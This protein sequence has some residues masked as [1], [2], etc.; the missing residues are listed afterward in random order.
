MLTAIAV[1]S[2]SG[3]KQHE[4]ELAKITD[5]CKENEYLQQLAQHISDKSESARQTVDDLR[6][7]EQTWTLAA[8]AEASAKRRC[9]LLA[10]ATEARGRQTSAASD[11]AA[12]E[13]IYSKAKLQIAK[14]QGT[15]NAVHTALKMK[16]EDG[17]VTSTAVGT[18]N[19]QKIAL[20]IANSNSA[21]CQFRVHSGKDP[22]ADDPPKFDQIKTMKLTAAAS[23]AN[24]LKPTTIAASGITGSCT[25]T[26]ATGGIQARLV[27]CQIAA[28]T[29]TTYTFSTPQ[30]TSGDAQTEVHIFADDTENSD[31]AAGLNNLPT[32]ATDTQR[33]AK[34]ICD[35]LKH[36]PPAVQSLKGSTGQTLSALDSIQLFIR[37]C[38]PDFQSI[39][40]AHSGPKAEKLKTYIKRAY[41]DTPTAFDTEFITNL[42]GANVPTRGKDKAGN[43]KKVSQKQPAT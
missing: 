36:Q 15:V 37:N 28:G 11:I 10:L 5:I 35:G 33:L 32:D 29:T 18:A 24:A 23:I 1:G 34:A 7:L 42:E 14:Q 30:A 40:D 20:K 39:G 13:Q 25:N 41:K 19:T 38:D 9:I 6:S 8:A 17:T 4:K 31:C 12:A 22:L 43:Q 2:V 3:K 27:G 16:I 26:A 21:P